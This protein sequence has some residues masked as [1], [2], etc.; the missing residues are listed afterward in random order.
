M[1]LEHMS[2]LGARWE[3]DGGAVQQERLNARTVCDRSVLSVSPKCEIR[4]AETNIQIDTHRK[5]ANKQACIYAETRRYS[6][7]AVASHWLLLS[8]VPL[9]QR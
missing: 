5:H 6:V 7:T 8:L 2:A 4:H 9:E 1:T 3:T